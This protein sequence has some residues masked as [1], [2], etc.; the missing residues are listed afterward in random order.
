MRTVSIVTNPFRCAISLVAIAICNRNP[1][2]FS[3][4][5]TRSSILKS[6]LNSGVAP[7]LSSRSSILKSLLNSEVAPRLSTRSSI[8]KSRL[9]SQLAPRSC[10]LNSLL[11]SRIPPRP[12]LATL[13]SPDSL[14]RKKIPQYTTTA[15]SPRDSLSRAHTKLPWSDAHTH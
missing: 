10:I 4:L 8:L 14:S 15:S 5:S 1:Q 2:V 12:G 11:N 9:N 6:L 3:R 7:R 13:L